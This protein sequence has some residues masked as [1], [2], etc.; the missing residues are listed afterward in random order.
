MSIIIPVNSLDEFGV[1]D[2]S[3]SHLLPP[4]AWTAA[5]NM[6]FRDGF[7]EKMLGDTATMGT[8]TVPP[9]HLQPVGTPTTFWWMYMGL[10]KVYATDGTTHF[11]ITRASGGDYS[12]TALESW[13]SGVLGGVPFCNNGFDAPQAWTSVSG[14]TPLVALANWPAN[15]TCKSL[16]AF[17]NFL[18]AMDVTES[19][20]RYPHLIRW[21][22][23]AA[24]GS[25]PSSWDFTN[26]ALDAGRRMI[27][28][29]GDF[30]IDGLGLGSIFLLYKENSIY[31]MQYVGGQQIFQTEPLTQAAG[32]IARRCAAEYRQGLHAVFSDGDLIS[33]DGTSVTSIASKRIRRYVFSRIDGSNYRK[34]FVLYNRNETEVWFAFPESGQSNPSLAA[35]WNYQD[36][37]WGFREMPAGVYGALGVVDASAQSDAWSAASGTWDSDAALWD[38][39]LYNP[40]LR[41]AVL[42]DPVGSRLLLADISA[43]F[44]SGSMTARVE[45]EGL[46]LPLSLRNSAP[47]DAT[48]WKQ[49]LNVWPQ[50]EGSN[51]TQIEVQVGVQ[52]DA[53]SA[54]VWQPAQTFIIGTSRKVDCLGASGRLL[55]I[56]FRST[57]TAIWKLSSY[58]VEFNARGKF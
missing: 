17:K 25:V 6:R 52:E 29:S 36:N 58:E 55:S 41:K 57:G 13:T 43:T 46:A 51:G 32:M 24:P 12:A 39:R 34:S 48:V 4:N 31:S 45:R 20:V 19:S 15:T 7:A 9:Y 30:L 27:G 18:I 42:A 33:V 8:P 3:P 49:F 28:D 5:Q 22:H 38:N 56:R 21:S 1:I 53:Q 37:K 11:D 10:A 35:V 40:S 14:G 2:D 44:V 26:T 47:P 50:F 54:T 16:R 23:P